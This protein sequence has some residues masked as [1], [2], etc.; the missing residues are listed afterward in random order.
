M[1]C[2]A[3]WMGWPRGKSRSNAASSAGFSFGIIGQTPSFPRRACARGFHVAL[4]SAREGDGAPVGAAVLLLH[5]RLAARVAPLG[6][7]SGVFLAAPGPR[8]AAF[9]LVPP[10]GLRL[11]PLAGGRAR[12]PRADL[13]GPP[14][15]SSSRGVVVPPGGA[16]APPGSV[17][18]RHARG[19]RPDPAKRRNRFASP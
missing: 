1:R 4:P 16:P 12:K 6:A 11:R 7:P 9:R 17:L 3:A 5:A 2:T 10:C 14:S 15:A 8:F 19:R 18:A 13:G